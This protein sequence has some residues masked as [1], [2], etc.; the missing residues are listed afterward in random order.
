MEEL[1]QNIENLK[2]KILVSLESL[3]YYI[4]FKYLKESLLN[5][6][7]SYQYDSH[8]NLSV[9]KYYA[10]L[11]FFYENVIEVIN[12]KITE[13]KGNSVFDNSTE[14]Q[15]NNVRKIKEEINKVLEYME[16]NYPQFI[17]KN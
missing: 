5:K 1:L 16:K 7:N 3:N 8:D 2:D 15:H 12:K 9:K 13:F 17:K 4:E 11:Q 10:W 6:L 14:E